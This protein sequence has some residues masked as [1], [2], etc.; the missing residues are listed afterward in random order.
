MATAPKYA[1]VMSVI[2]RRVREGD[3]LLHNIPGERKIAEETGVSYMTARRAVIELLDRKVLIRR[4][5]GTLDIHPGYNHRKVQTKVVLLYPAYPSPYLAQLRQIVSAALEKH[6]L[7]LRPVQYVHWDDPIVRE[8]VANGG[9]ALIIPSANRVP[10]RILRPL[11]EQKV[12]ALDGDFSAEGIPS[13]RLFPDRH[14]EQVFTHLAAMGHRR[15]DCVNTQCRNPEIDRR[16]HLWREWLA[17]EGGEGRLWDDPAPS[18][19]DPTPY[20]HQMMCRLLEEKRPQATAFVCTTFPAAMGTIR[21]HWERGYRIGENVSVCS[22]NI[23]PPARYCCPSVTGLDMPDLS[24][25][26]DRCFTWFAD[27]RPWRGAA[28]L[29]PRQAVFFAGESAGPPAKTRVRRRSTR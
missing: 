13:I 14:I 26:L 7:S 29:E 19:T 25:V 5:N 6:G 11:S 10:T 17:R 18:F 27:D 22:M 2:E 16:I 1:Q 12:V 4:D 23:E 3:Y 28:L 8:A 15:I 24:S 9:G 20:A 21:A